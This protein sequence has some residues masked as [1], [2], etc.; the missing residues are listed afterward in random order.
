MKVKGIGVELFKRPCQ[1]TVTLS[2]EYKTTILN[3]EQ[4]TST[5]YF[6]FSPCANSLFL[7]QEFLTNQRTHN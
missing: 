2:F 7:L 6:G 3:W 4:E 5:I 1:E